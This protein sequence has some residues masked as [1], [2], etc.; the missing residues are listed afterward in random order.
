MPRQPTLSPDD[1]RALFMQCT[2][3]AIREDGLKNATA[4]NIA[5]RA[6]YTAGTLYTCFR[7]LDDLLLQVQVTILDRLQAELS[8]I[9]T[10]AEPSEA[11][12]EVT[13]A[14]LAFARNNSELWSLIQQDADK[15]PPELHRRFIDGLNNLRAIF[16][17]ALARRDSANGTAA[18]D[19]KSAD[20]LWMSAHGLTG[21]A[22][23]RK[24][25]I[26]TPQEIE[27]LA[28]SIGKWL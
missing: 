16:A 8:E 26:F 9:C 11:V 6:G 20:L 2:E 22:I 4:R 24:M 3:D 27:A 1:M 14:Y 15:G 13:R 28:S 18:A 23:S 21:L 5:A 17:E 10:T 12:A 19:K 7:N 25:L